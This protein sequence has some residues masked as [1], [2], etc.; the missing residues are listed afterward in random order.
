MYTD[1]T[2]GETTWARGNIVL[3]DSRFAIGSPTD[4]GLFF[5]FNSIYGLPSDDPKAWMYQNIAYIA[6]IIEENQQIN[7]IKIEI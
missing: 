4:F 5:R 6:G 1:V 3:K 2:I 7:A